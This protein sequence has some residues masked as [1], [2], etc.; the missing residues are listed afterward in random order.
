MKYLVWAENNNKYR[1]KTSWVKNASELFEGE[2]MLSF[3][4]RQEADSHIRVS[5]YICCA[6]YA[7]TKSHELYNHCN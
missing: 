6:S 2:K 3:N 7:I 4:S 5:G 1:T